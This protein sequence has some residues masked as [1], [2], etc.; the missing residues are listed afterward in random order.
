MTY[1]CQFDVSRPPNSRRICGSCIQ[2]ES[3]PL[4]DLNIDVPG[5]QPASRKVPGK[6]LIPS[7]LACLTVMHFTLQEA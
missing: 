7:F 4:L 5:R 6:P 2:I 1:C 3:R